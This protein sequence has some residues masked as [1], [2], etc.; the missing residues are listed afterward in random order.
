LFNRPGGRKR[1]ADAGKEENTET[2]KRYSFCPKLKFVL[3]F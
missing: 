2:P 1:K 3:G